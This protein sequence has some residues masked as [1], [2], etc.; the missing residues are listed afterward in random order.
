M[1]AEIKSADFLAFT[2]FLNQFIEESHLIFTEKSM[3]NYSID[4]G[5]I[6]LLV[7]EIEKGDFVKYFEK[8]SDKVQWGINFQNLNKIMSKVPMKKRNEKI[9]IQLVTNPST[10][11]IN[12]VFK[13]ALR[14][15]IFS[16]FKKK[17]LE[18]IYFE[19]INE[20][21][22][23]FSSRVS[24]ITSFGNNLTTLLEEKEVID[25]KWKIALNASEV[26]T[27]REEMRG[28][29][30]D[31]KILKRSISE[32]IK[33]LKIG[34]ELNKKLKKLKQR[35]KEHPLWEKLSDVIHLSFVEVVDEY[36]KFTKR[37]RKLIKDNLE[38]LVSSY[39]SLDIMTDT[40]EIKINTIEIGDSGLRPEALEGLKYPNSFEFNKEEFERNIKYGIIFSETLTISCKK[41]KVKF[42]NEGKIGGFNNNYDLKS[43]FLTSYKFEED[44]EL[45]FALEY[46]KRIMKSFKKVKK[47]K[48]FLKPQ[49]PLKVVAY[50][51]SGIRAVNYLAPRIEEDDEDEDY[52]DDYDSNIRNHT[53][54]EYLLSN[55][56]L[57]GD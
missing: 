44:T 3:A 47:I 10:Y 38:I 42:W 56:K 25:G 21:I 17:I 34:T 50:L 37:N 14:S 22:D 51:G 36:R 46:L 54:D 7:I 28:G 12:E 5:R 24:A 23:E 41:G 15:E 19:Y 6:I 31:P 8:I 55:M 26:D 45:T 40:A 43:D 52:D 2:T 33:E 30:A 1:E 9:I 13:I 11:E 48:I 16:R 39:K 4:D 32:T 57:E 49:T 27:I 35:K 53:I 29:S 20:K 18:T